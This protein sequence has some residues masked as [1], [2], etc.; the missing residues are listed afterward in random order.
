[1]ADRARVDESVFDYL[2]PRLKQYESEHAELAR[3]V[4]RSIAKVTQ[5]AE[6]RVTERRRALA[7]AVQQLESCE[8]QRAE[9]EEQGN[10]GADCG[11]YRRQAA[12]C[13]AELARAIKGRAMIV[14]AAAQFRHA[15]SR[16]T[17]SMERIILDGQKLLRAAAERAERYQKASTY[18]PAAT[19]LSAVGMS[20]GAAL[21]GSSAPTTM[22]R[23]G[24]DASAF[25]AGSGMRGGTLSWRDL[26][27]VMVPEW[28]PLGYGLIPLALL[29]DDGTV[30]SAADF[31]TNPNK[32]PLRD[33]RWAVDALGEVVLPAMERKADPLEYLQR[34]D[35]DEGRSGAK[36][37]AQT[38]RG[39]FGDDAIALSALPDG[40]FDVTNGYHRIWLLRQAYADQVP[41]R[42]IGG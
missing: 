39:F 14:E 40:T 22:G 25:G 28:L 24:P 16:Y 6:E 29:P 21:L 23:I 32:H 2:K 38:Y 20:G 36:S 11:G 1:M 17:A 27:G 13:E 30:T 15:Q 7:R 8:A 19:L 42:I 33:L 26:P 12:T 4:S 34:R 31:E 9:D 3:D 41:A 35:T 18:V 10:A 5:E 37:Y